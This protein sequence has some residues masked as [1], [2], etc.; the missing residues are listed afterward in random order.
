MV[1]H[2]HFN[3]IVPFTI[4]IFG[5]V[6]YAP[7]PLNLIKTHSPCP[8]SKREVSSDPEK[9]QTYEFTR[10]RSP[11]NMEPEELY[12]NNWNLNQTYVFKGQSTYSMVDKF[13]EVVKK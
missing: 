10:S 9:P 12:L 5:Y 6:R 2:K 4:L 13:I 1:D 11:F 3:P 7:L 8:S